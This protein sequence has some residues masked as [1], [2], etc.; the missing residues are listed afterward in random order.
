MENS[1]LSLFDA[2]RSSL[3]NMIKSPKALDAIAEILQEYLH[4]NSWDTKNNVIDY[5]TGKG[6]FGEF[7]ISIHEF[8]GVYWVTAPEFDDD[9][10]FTNVDDARSFAG[11]RFEPFITAHLNDTDSEN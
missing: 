7:Q 5:F 2:L 11:K 4:E 3:P 10:Y 9:G 8:H 6:S 1:K